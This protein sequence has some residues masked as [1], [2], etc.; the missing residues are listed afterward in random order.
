MLRIRRVL[1]KRL[2]N[3]LD[4]L[5]SGPPGFPGVVCGISSRVSRIADFLMF[6]MSLYVLLQLNG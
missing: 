3:V 2:V 6:S 5:D 4:S 1:E